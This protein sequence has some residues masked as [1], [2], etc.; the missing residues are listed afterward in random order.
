MISAQVIILNR[1]ISPIFSEI[2]A[3]KNKMVSVIVY[4]GFISLIV[5]YDI[6]KDMNL[7]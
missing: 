1:Y 5:S 3:T 4:G 2:E 6:I 7:Y